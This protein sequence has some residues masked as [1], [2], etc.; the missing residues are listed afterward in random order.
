MEYVINKYEYCEYGVLE[1]DRL[2]I[3]EGNF[4]Y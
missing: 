2:W 4:R 3:K 1:E